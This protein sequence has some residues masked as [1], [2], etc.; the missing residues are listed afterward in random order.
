MNEN[1]GTV[2]F[3]LVA[4]A[5]GLALIRH[6]TF[7]VE[8]E[9]IRKSRWLPNHASLAAWLEYVTGSHVVWNG[10]TH[11]YINDLKVVTDGSLNYDGSEIVTPVTPA[12][13]FGQLKKVLKS[14]RGLASADASCGIHVHIGLLPESGQNWRSIVGT[15]DGATALNWMYRAVVAYDH[16]WD[17]FC[18]VLAPSRRESQWAYP[19]SHQLRRLSRYT[20]HN[21]DDSKFAEYVA[22]AMPHPVGNGS[23]CNGSQSECFESLQGQ[24]DRYYAVNL[25]AFRKYGTIEYRQHG[26]STNPNHVV[27]WVKLLNLFTLACRE[28]FGDGMRKPTKYPST[29]NGLFDWI[30]LRDNDPLRTHWVR[31]ERRFKGELHNGQQCTSCNRR[32]CDNDDYCPHNH[33]SAPNEVLSVV[34]DANSEY[35][36]DCEEHYDYCECGSV[37]LVGMLGLLFLPLVA[38]IN[39]GVGAYHWAGRR[40]KVKGGLKRLWVGLTSR[41]KDSAGLAFRSPNRNPNTGESSEYTGMWVHKAPAPAN[42]MTGVINSYVTPETPT[43]LMHTRFATNGD[44]NKLN[45]HP[46]RDPQGLGVTMVHNGVIWNDDEVFQAIGIEPVTQCDSEAAAAC[47]AEGGIKEVVKQ[48]EGS[49]SLIWTD[50]R[51]GNNNLHFWTNGSN[52]LAFGRLDDAKSG[53]VVVASTK[54]HL[55]GAFK[56]RLKS[57]WDATI[58]KHYIVAD[59]GSI[60]SEHI[61]GSESSR[62]YVFTSNYRY[63][64][65]PKHSTKTKKSKPKVNTT[66]ERTWDWWDTEEH[67]GVRPDGSRYE[68]PQYLDQMDACDIAE[69][70]EGMYDPN[71]FYAGYGDY[72]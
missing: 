38:I 53:A 14:L 65:W 50:D 19:P 47:L 12:G 28:P 49:M 2:A 36:G 52:P 43:L 6:P 57:V 40:Q 20:N 21:N 33:Y 18:S 42:A 26:G 63:D 39:C 60:S 31:R 54:A 1:V 7:G 46:H 34:R 66:K 16:F 17:A 22:N 25:D 51:D 72:Q 3:A 64:D 32:T 5:V 69:V 58:G 62:G 30:G 9:V 48:C 29:V 27:A 35:C 55:E 44:I 68:L 8:I 56:S 70:E 10:Y 15:D 71:G 23:S 11:D 45:A 4:L 41:G 59:D 24:G 37:S 61:A 67:E 13:D